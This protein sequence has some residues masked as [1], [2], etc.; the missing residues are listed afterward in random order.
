M[1]VRSAFELPENKQ[2]LRARA[3]KLEWITIALMLV[4]ILILYLTLG[5]SQAM[6][7]AWIEDMLSLIPPIAFLVAIHFETRAP[8]R[9]HPYGYFRAID[10]AYLAGSLALLVFGLY[11]LFDSVMSLIK[12]EHPSIG[13]VVLFGE[14]IWLG[15]LML[16]AL[17]YTG[18]PPVIVGLLK[19]PL[20][21]E[22]HDKVL[23]ADA[24]MNK[25]DWLTS[26]AAMVGVV[27]IGLGYWWLDAVAAII[28]SADV[29]KDG[30]KNLKR[31]CEDLLDASPRNVDTNEQ[32]P[33]PARVKSLLEDLD[34]IAAAEVRMREEGHVYSGEALIVPRD[35]S[36]ARE[37]MRRVTQAKESILKLHWRLHDFSVIPLNQLE[38]DPG[39]S[40]VRTRI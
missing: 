12:A 29:T 37:L 19:L 1:R 20:A 7:T 4:N 25:A 38:D 17:A 35:I 36:E 9:K 3:I 21:R 26:V 31:V 16:A 8:D 28:I 11:L 22:L 39:S 32:D 34:W 14:T 27:G 10:I 6:R 18:I 30:V 24:D 15:W 2:P 33:L 23:R 13:T 40:Q 5:N